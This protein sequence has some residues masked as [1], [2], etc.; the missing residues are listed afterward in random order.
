MGPNVTGKNFIPRFISSRSLALKWF[1]VRS[2]RDVLPGGKHSGASI[3]ITFGLA[4]TVFSII[5]LSVKSKVVSAFI[6]DNKQKPVGL[7]WT[8]AKSKPTIIMCIEA[9]HNELKNGYAPANGSHKRLAI[10]IKNH[11]SYMFPHKRSL[12]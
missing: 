1:V 9:N 6:S 4:L 12:I 10:N 5:S 11:V 3:A 8:P 2:S 7:V